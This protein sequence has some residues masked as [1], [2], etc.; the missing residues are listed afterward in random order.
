MPE[1]GVSRNLTKYLLW[2]PFCLKASYCKPFHGPFVF[3]STVGCSESYFAYVK[4]HEPS[5]VVLLQK[6][7]EDVHAEIKL[8]PCSVMYCAEVH[9]AT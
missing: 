4:N 8:C 7:R 5:T 1:N 3:S 2:D 9:P 6:Y